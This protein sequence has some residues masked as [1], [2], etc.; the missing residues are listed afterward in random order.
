MTT[1][2]A[3]GRSVPGPR[4]MPDT[5]EFHLIRVQGVELDRAARRVRVRDQLFNL[6]RKEFELLEFLMLN[7]G[8]GQ[9][10]QKLLARLW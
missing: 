3:T 8:I 9:T 2:T 6:P 7:A 10:R 4:P 1:D 5:N